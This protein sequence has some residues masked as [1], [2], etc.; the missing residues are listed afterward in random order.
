MKIRKGVAFLGVAVALALVAYAIHERRRQAAFHAACWAIRA[1]DA[2]DDAERRLA[3]AGGALYT[4]SS[5]SERVWHIDAPLWRRIGIC[6]VEID[7]HGT[8]IWSKS[9]G[10]LPR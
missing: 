5:R 2:V 6:S 9:K 3:D 4:A 7:E 10:N 8:V 1:G